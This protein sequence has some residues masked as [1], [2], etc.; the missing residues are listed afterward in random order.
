MMKELGSKNN[1]EID[2]E[3]VN[4]KEVLENATHSQAKDTTRSISK[5]GALSIVNAKTG[6]RLVFSNKLIERI[7]NP[8]R[9]QISYNENDK[10]I[11]VGQAL[12]NKEN[13]VLK[14]SGK[15]SI[16]Y[17]K[18]LVEEITEALELDFNNRTSL[19][20]DTVEYL[21]NDEGQIAIIEIED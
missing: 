21:E 15:K 6:S 10:T 5:A 18:A 2:E 3:S 19:T 16:I 7:G 17:C 13:Y 12:G 4:I 14:I 9:V 11:I 1:V 20:F 8:E